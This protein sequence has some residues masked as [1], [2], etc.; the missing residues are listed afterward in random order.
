MPAELSKRNLTLVAKTIQTTAN[1]T[2]YGDKEP[3]MK[4][5]NDFVTDSF[6]PVQEFLNRVCVEPRYK[7]VAS[8]QILSAVV[9]DSAKEM[10]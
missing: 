10:S 7:D 2:T 8:T 1:M 5:M 9:I 4:T 3:F 6:P